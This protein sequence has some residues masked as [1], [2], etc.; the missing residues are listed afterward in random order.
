[1]RTEEEQ[2]LLERSAMGKLWRTNV[3]VPLPEESMSNRVLSRFQKYFLFTKH[4]A[5]MNKQFPAPFPIIDKAEF[6][7][8]N[9]A[10]LSLERQKRTIF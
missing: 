7:K 10:L 8:K 4:W 3:K 6:Q 9:K 2:E 5:K 1:M